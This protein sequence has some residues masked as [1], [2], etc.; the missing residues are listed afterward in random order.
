M[1][2]HLHFLCEGHEATS[3]LLHF[4]KCLKIKSSRFYAGSFD[5][6][7]WQKAYYEHIPRA[8]DPIE[9]VAWYIWM[10]PV[11]KGIAQKPSEYACSGS[12]TGWTMP[13]DWQNVDWRPP[14]KKVL[15]AASETGS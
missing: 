14:W 6:T 2:D 1:P 7:L 11:R 9:G 4:V 3:D 12:F 10:N 8:D 15:S 5:R 13:T